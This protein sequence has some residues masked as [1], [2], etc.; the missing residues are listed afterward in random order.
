MHALSVSAALKFGWHTFQ[1]RPWFFMGAT[2][3]VFVIEWVLGALADA[4]GT[5]GPEALLATVVN[6]VG[7]VLLGMGTTA[8]Y[9]KAHDSVASVG[10]VDL[11]HPRPF[12]KY[13]GTTILYGIAILLAMAPFIA[14][15]A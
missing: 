15:M 10:I 14:A 12:W 11:W 1:K 9:L 5:A 4:I 13:L 7:S 2:L 8:L 6:A 3:T